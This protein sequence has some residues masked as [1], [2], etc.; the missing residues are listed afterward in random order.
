M[1]TKD[2]V[3]QLIKALS[4]DKDFYD[5]WHSTISMCFYDAY[6]EDKKNYKNSL[7]IH[8][9]SNNGADKFLKLLI[10]K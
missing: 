7:D 3:E 8:R 2:A 1:K 4:K 9:I 10:D 6:N 5:T